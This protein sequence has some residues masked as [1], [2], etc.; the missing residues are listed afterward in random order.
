MLREL[1]SDNGS[2][3][4]AWEG[5]WILCFGSL[6]SMRSLLSKIRSEQVEQALGAR[7]G[8]IRRRQASELHKSAEKSARGLNARAE[9]V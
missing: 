4:G 7:Y 6:G 1:V 8:A 2:I 5:A 3:F 9:I